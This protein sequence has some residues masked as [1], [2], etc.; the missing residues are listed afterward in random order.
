VAGNALTTMERIFLPEER[1]VF[2][3]ATGVG[4]FTVVAPPAGTYEFWMTYGEI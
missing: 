3:A 4:L 1:P 2:N